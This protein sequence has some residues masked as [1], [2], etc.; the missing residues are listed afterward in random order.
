MNNDKKIYEC[1]CCGLIIVADKKT[2]ASKFK[3]PQCEYVICLQE[4]IF[5][6]VK[7]EDLFLFTKKVDDKEVKV[8]KSES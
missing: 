2:N 4:H 8:Y 6:L 5:E 3:C 7:F 1:D